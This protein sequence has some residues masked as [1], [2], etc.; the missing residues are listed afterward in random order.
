MKEEEDPARPLSEKG[1]KDIDK[2]SNFLKG[3]GIWVSKIFHSGKLRAKQT[4]EKL[5]EAIN[6]S[7]GIIETDGLSSLDDPKIWVER[8]EKEENDI[9]IIGHLPHLSKLASLLLI[10]DTRLEVI[11][12]KMGGVICIEKNQERKW[13][14]QWMVTPDIIG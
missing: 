2:I 8:L 7:D 3:K 14:I 1:C 6:P 4:S 13:S 11:R 12:F 5:F 9:M 10:A